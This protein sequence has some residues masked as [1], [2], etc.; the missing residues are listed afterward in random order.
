[1][2]RTARHGAQRNLAAL[3]I[4]AMSRLQVPETT[5]PTRVSPVG[6]V[7][8]STTTLYLVIPGDSIRLQVVRAKILWSVS[9]V[10]AAVPRRAHIHSAGPK[11]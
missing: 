5:T 6:A 9:D 7:I 3:E 1:M 2:E 11:A 8:S 4:A 10:L